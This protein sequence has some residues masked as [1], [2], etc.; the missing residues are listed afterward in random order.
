MT[1]RSGPQVITWGLVVLA[2]LVLIPL[3]GMLGMLTMGCGI[4]GGSIMGG[5]VDGT[6]G[7]HGW[8]ALWRVLLAGVRIALSVIV[9]RGISRR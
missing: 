4:M 6:V 9:I 3:L 1:T 8:G 7:M 2:I 5:G